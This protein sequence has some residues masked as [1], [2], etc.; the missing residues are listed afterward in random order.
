[1]SAR[2]STPVVSVATVS[3]FLWHS[4]VTPYV[5]NARTRRSLVPNI[6]LSPSSCSI[7]TSMYFYI[8]FIHIHLHY[9]LF[10][11]LSLCNHTRMLSPATRS[12]SHENY[13]TSEPSYHCDPFGPCRTI[14]THDLPKI[15]Q[16]TASRLVSGVELTFVNT[17]Q[18]FRERKRMTDYISNSQGQVSAQHVE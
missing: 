8:Y 14:V 5:N 18:L 10:V 17:S 1:M 9:P 11:L 2:P 3:Q 4:L 7:K 13:R 15:L 6:F 16:H 12:S